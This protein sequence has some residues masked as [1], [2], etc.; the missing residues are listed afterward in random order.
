V[1]DVS[2][3]AGAGVYRPLIAGFDPARLAVAGD[4]LGKKMTRLFWL[5]LLFLLNACA[6]LPGKQVQH[7]SDLVIEKDTVWSGKIQIDGQVE[8]LRGAKLTIAP[9]T[10][11]SFVYRDKNRDG[12][13]D[14]RLI[15]KG[16][17][18]AIGTSQQPIRFRSARQNPQPGDW[19]EIAVDFSKNVH[20]RYCELRDSA[21]T[22]HAHFTNGLVEDCHIHH[23]IDGCRIGQATFTFQHNLVE[24]NSGKGINFRN[25]QVT[26]RNN[27]IRHN[28]AGVFLFENNLPFEIVG[29]NFTD[30]QHHLRLGDFYTADVAVRG[31]WWGTSERATI[32]QHIY[33][34]SQDAAIGAVTIEPLSVAVENAGPR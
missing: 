8:V 21:Y 32:R 23:N 12:L 15:V 4:S 30:N 31:N 7:F 25:S 5:L 34:Q 14:G 10:D 3:A 16:I 1:G 22:L 26:V 6:V 24:H 11:I 29:N 13:G 18:Q 9:G 20:L 28:V 27:V 17:L 19:L 33:D 2:K